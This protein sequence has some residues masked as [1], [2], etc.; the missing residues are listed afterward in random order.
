MQFWKRK[1]T[2]SCP[3][4]DRHRDNGKYRWVKYV[5]PAAGLVSL[6]WF[7]ARVIPKPSRA[8]YPCQRMA[9]P[10]ASG[11]VAWLVGLGAAAAAFRKAKLSF[12]RRRFVAG[13]VCLTVSIGALWLALSATAEKLV[14][15]EPQAANSPMGTAHGINPGRVVWVHD[16]DATDWD[17]PGDGHLW[18]DEHTNPA[19]CEQMMSRAIRSLTGESTDAKAWDALFRYHNKARGKGDVGYRPGEKITIKVNFVGFIRTMRSVNR[20]TYALDEWQD[21]MNTSPQLIAALLKELTQVAGVRQSDIAIGDSLAYFASEY[22]DMLH[23][24]FPDVTYLDCKGGS[25]RTKMELSTEPLYWSCRPEGVQQDYVPRA[26]AEAEYLINFA[27][28]KAHSGAGVTLCAKNHYGSFF[29]APPDKGYY[30]MHKSGFSKGSAEYRNLVDLTGHSQ[31]GGKTLLYLLDGLYSGVH[32]KD[33]VPRKWASA[34]FNGDWTSSLFAS[35]DPVAIDSVGL[36]F[37]QVDLPEAACM[38]GTDDYL[39]EAALADNPPS[40]TFYDPD[41]ATATVRLASLGVHE[42]WNNPQ[43]KKYSRN[44]GTGDGI[45]LVAVT[46]PGGSLKGE[47]FGD[48]NAGN[49]HPQAALEAAT[50]VAP[51][52]KVVKLADGFEFT[53]GPAV[54]A[55]GNVFFTDQPNNRIQKWSVDGTS[56]GG[57]LSVFHDNP[58]RSN[59]L[60]FDASGNLLACADMDNELWSIDM[61]GKAT[62]LVKD[63]KGKKLNGPNDLWPDPKGGIYFTDPLYKR[64]YWTRGPAM[65]QDGQHVYYLAPDR[66]TLIRVTEDL[67]QPNGIIGTPDGTYLYVADI[68]D[69]KTYRYRT[70]ADGTLANKKLFCSMGSDGMTIDNEGNIY[71]TG[72]GVTVFNPAGEKIE[73]IPIDAGWTANVC[74]GGADRHTLFVTA[75]KSLYALRMRVRGVQ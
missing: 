63:Y 21:Y 29:R 53:E 47:A 5:F 49:H 73:Q 45:E 50:P 54:D 15:A 52:A 41:H 12:S 65:Q 59:G 64:P 67:V 24:Q 8:L 42:H 61:S 38:A 7:L 51:G 48:G 46:E 31:L 35:Q 22:Y 9:F 6:I 60:F 11:F 74:F 17:G 68:G 18:Q 44:L 16:P 19:V 20:D 69:R 58:G 75:Q 3:K 66:K 62:V 28:L 40:G 36:D 43:E 34:P 57:K 55:H 56:P 23:R 2:G 71:L 13:V 10:M 25:G 4:A 39:H 27:N 14:L 70:N 32:P 26:Y 1:N 37:L 72:K 33:R 30:D